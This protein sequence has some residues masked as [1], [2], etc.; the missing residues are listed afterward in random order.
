M[1]KSQPDKKTLRAER[2]RVNFPVGV[3]PWIEDGWLYAVFDRPAENNDE[4]A[5]ADSHGYD[6]LDYPELP[7]AFAKLREASDKEIVQFANEWGIPY[8]EE[9]GIPVA[10]VRKEA[11]RVW[12]ALEFTVAIRHTDDARA[13]ELAKLAMT[14]HVDYEPKPGIPLLLIGL[15]D[16]FEPDRL[17]SRRLAGFDPRQWY[18]EDFPQQPGINQAG[19]LLSYLLADSLE[20][21]NRTVAW[22]PIAQRLD[23]GFTS[24]DLVEYMYSHI[25]ETGVE[26][27]NTIH[28]IGRCLECGS[29]FRKN[30]SDQKFCPRYKRASAESKSSR[31]WSNCG[32]RYHARERRKLDKARREKQS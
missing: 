26:E 20:N 7:Y 12:L 13:L 3:R 9:N 32:D 6:P 1:D 2:H 4:S 10:E 19:Q 29:L 24:V 15:R 8:Y 30:R 11:S 21:V 22:E 27:S 31:T 14:D 16:A 25:V 28:D 17:D 5:D 18:N 23:V